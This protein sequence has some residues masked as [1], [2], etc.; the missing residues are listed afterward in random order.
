M[1]GSVLHFTRATARRYMND[2]TH[3]RDTCK[4]IRKIGLVR[5]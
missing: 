2:G 3:A 4:R 5:Y 1:L